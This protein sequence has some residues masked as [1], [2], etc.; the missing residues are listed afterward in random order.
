MVGKADLCSCHQALAAVMLLQD[1]HA[2]VTGLVEAEQDSQETLCFT[3]TAGCRRRQ[4]ICEAHHL[5]GGKT[6][7]S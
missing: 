4:S 6:A 7:N 1:A 5:L 3:V 2:L